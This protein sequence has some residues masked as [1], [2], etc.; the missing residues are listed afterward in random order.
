MANEITL[1]DK[2]QLPSFMQGFNNDEYAAYM[3]DAY[4]SLSIKGKVFALVRNGERQV[5]YVPGTRDTLQR[6]NVIILKAGARPAKRYYKGTY[7]DGEEAIKPA[8][9]SFDG[10]H[11]DQASTEPQCKG[12]GA[13]PFNA[14]GTARM[15]DGTVGKGKAC[16]DY[17]RLAICP[18]DASN[19]D[20]IYYLAVPAASIKAFSNYVTMLARHKM[21]LH[22]VRTEISFDPSAATPKLCFNAIGVVDNQA[23]WA[24]LEELRVSPVVSNIVNGA[25]MVTEAP[26]QVVRKPTPET[27][28]VVQA[29]DKAVDNILEGAFASAPVA[30]APAPAPTPAP[31]PEKKPEP[32]VVSDDLNEALNNLGF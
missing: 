26:V 28:E 27:K 30:P 18:A 14:F 12:C 22:G 31:A 1:L 32:A 19:H 11:P 25:A 23:E 24:H 20:D 29:K 4:A 21:P 13:C 8:C 16:T 6:I 3:S 2:I 15:T 7:K 5:L 9:F 10:L 17:I